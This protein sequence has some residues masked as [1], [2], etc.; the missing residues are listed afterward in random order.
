MVCN[1]EGQDGNENECA[2]KRGGGPKRTALAA[3]PSQASNAK[4][5]S[6]DECLAKEEMNE[7]GV[8][9]IE[10]RGSCTQPDVKR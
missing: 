9:R 5:I 7:N 2:K 4:A 3:T 8:A 1:N 10:G 6:E